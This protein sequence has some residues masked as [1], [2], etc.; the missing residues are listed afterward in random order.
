MRQH[1]VGV[2]RQQRQQL[3]L[4]RRQPDLL[5]AARRR[6]GGRSR[7]SGRRHC[8]RSTARRLALGD[9]PQRDADPREQFLGAERLGHVVVGADVERRDLVR[10]AAARRQDDDRHRWTARG[11]GGRPRR[12]PDPAGRDRARSDRAARRPTRLHRVGPV[13]DDVD[14]VAARRAA[15]APPPA[16][17]T[18]RRRPGECARAVTPSLQPSAGTTIVNRAPP[19]GQFSAQTGRAPPP[20]CPRAI[21]SPM[22]VPERRSLRVAR[23]DRTARTRAADRPA[24]CPGP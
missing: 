10:L 13:P 1:A 15:A 24:R 3:E 2:A 9:A 6:G 23:R 5:V 22:P 4:L 19:S 21:A 12:L 20:A 7:W 16:E 18:H 17:S 11:C 14:L 8:M